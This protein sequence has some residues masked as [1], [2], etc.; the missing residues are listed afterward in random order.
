MQEATMNEQNQDDKKENRSEGLL[1][2]G[3]D[4]DDNDRYEV[5]E[6][7]NLDQQS[8]GVRHLGNLPEDDDEAAAV[9]ESLRPK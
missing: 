7:I 1:P 9:A 5:A 6:E 2:A 8:D 3:E 4:D